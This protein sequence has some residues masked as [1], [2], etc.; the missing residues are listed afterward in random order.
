MNGLYIRRRVGGNGNVMV[1]FAWEL[2]HYQQNK[3]YVHAMVQYCTAGY[4]KHVLQISFEA[5]SV[6][7]TA[8]KPNSKHISTTAILN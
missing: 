3:L 6:C 4:Y 2:G 5:I 8:S 7:K 1:I